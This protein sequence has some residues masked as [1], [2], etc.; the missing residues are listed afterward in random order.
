MQKDQMH[1]EDMRN[2]LLFFVFSIALYFAYDYFVAEPHARAVRAY[3]EAQVQAAALP[4]AAAAEEAFKIRPRA[5]VIAADTR[6]PV[7]SGELKGSI[8]LRGGRIDDL[9]LVNY[10]ETLE[11]TRNI[12]LLSPRGTDF[13]RYAEY[14]WVAAEGQND[15]LPGPDTIWQ[16]RGNGVLSPKNPVTLVWDNGQG[17]VFER[18]FALDENYMFT[19]TQRVRNNTGAP[20]TLHPY[21]LLSQ[22]GLP[23]DFA[24]TYI[25]HEGPI[26][27]IG[28]ELQ[29]VSYKDMAKEQAISKQAA[30]GWLGLTEK[31]W[32]AAL[33]PSQAEMSTYRFSYQ[34]PP[35]GNELAKPRYQADF[36]GAAVKV[37][38]GDT[39]QAASHLFVGAK[40]V[41]LLEQYERDLGLPHFDLAVDFGIFYFMT[42]PFFYA[43]HFFGKLVGN[44]GIAII[45][46]TLFV[47]MAAF[48]LTN[49]SYR[50]FAKMK[51]VSPQILEIR[52]KHGDNKQKL[53]EELIKMYEREGVNPLAGCLP[54]LVQ[55]P[56]FFAFYK[57]L[58]VTIEMRH[59]PFYGWIK[60]LSAADPTT[61]FNLFGLI[62]WDPPGFLQIGIWPCM[63]LVAMMIQKK[64]NP[65]P[66]DPIQRDMMN[67]FPFVITFVLSRFASGLVIYWTISA[68]LSILQQ[69][70]IMRSLGVPIHLF[71]ET[72]EEKK[73]EE[74]IAHG[75]KGVH[76]LVEMAE[77]QAEEA[78]TGEPSARKPISPPKPKKKKKK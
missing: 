48:P 8:S 52:Q 53:Q 64:L 47:R 45:I 18:E 15:V 73:L 3:N 29:E 21:G 32:L 12:I 77:E 65:P 27:Y 39:A 7:S 13:P 58:F 1:P 67:Y 60:D 37:L 61:V 26:G 72:E 19:V 6:I 40:K 2:L 54:I 55:I 34:A 62:P 70:F 59:A 68:A 44:F 35:P 11:K 23:P 22:T 76:P 46:M 4:D 30:Q 28:D 69:M 74:A 38:P 20:V 56:I 71:G 66:Q 9:A 75:P 63:M 49:V 50:S 14:G 51:K 57:V 25:S 31:Y 17:L 16:L 42:K 24:G 78:I 10:F 33:I 43:L 5:D 41:L 36:T